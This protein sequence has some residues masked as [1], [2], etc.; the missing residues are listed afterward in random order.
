MGSIR[1]ELNPR[2]LGK[3]C[4]R[5]LS[6]SQHRL[7]AQLSSSRPRPGSSVRPRPQRAGDTP[8]PS[9]CPRSRERSTRYGVAIESK[10]NEKKTT[11]SPNPSAL[12]E[13]T[14]RSHT[15]WGLGEVSEV[16]LCAGTLISV[17]RGGVCHRSLTR[18]QISTSRSAEGVSISEY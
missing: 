3:A 13:Q 5:I 12:R 15:A 16:F 2:A 4:R 17:T 7:A 1:N 9:Q 8:T 6:S 14:R 10:E 11:N 18:F